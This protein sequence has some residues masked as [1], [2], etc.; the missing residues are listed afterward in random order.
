MRTTRALT[1]LAFLALT[2]VAV[3]V[4]QGDA[5]RWCPFGGIEALYSYATT[6]NFTCS[7]GISNFY[8]LGGVLL[9]TLLLRRAFCGYVCPIGTISEW[10]RRG[11]VRIGIPAIP[12][13]NRLDRVLALLKYPVL[14]VIL[15]ITFRS[16]E[17]LFRGFDPCYALISRHGKDITYWAYV[18]SGGILIGSLL[19]ML[20]FC[21]WLCPLAAVLAP[22]SR[23]GLMRVRRHAEPCV[24]C[25]KCTKAC[26]MALPVDQ[27]LSVS[28]SRCTTCLDCVAACPKAKQ[29]AISWGPVGSGNARWPA[30]LVVPVILVC[31]G[32][33]VAATYAWPMPSF[34]HTRGTAPETVASV[35]LTV[36]GVT[37]RGSSAGLIEWLQR[38]DE[39]AIT[40]YLDVDI[41][42]SADGGRV[43]I[44][45]DPAK[46]SP[47]EI[48]R[49]LVMPYFDLFGGTINESP[50]TVEG[51]APTVEEL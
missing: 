12:V 36:H 16:G 21:R 2:I 39:Y 25:G 37:C 24:D 28:A 44:A 33:A 3:Y 13:P 43:I 42:P 18:V 41:W 19:I 11:A 14:I 22:F 15:Y 10:A 35:D 20:P 6:G 40:G 48:R 8:I 31:V 38:D 1:Q 50:Y 47:A 17:L 51:Y 4:I 29:G 23:L 26:P 32:A 49:A 45:Y 7:L 27:T 5:E 46:T 9:M 34:N 30:A